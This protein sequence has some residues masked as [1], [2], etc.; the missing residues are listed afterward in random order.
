MTHDGLVTGPVG[1]TLDDA[2]EI[3]RRHKVEKL[4]IVDDAGFLKGLITVKDIQ[5]KIQFPA[6]RSEEHTSE[7]Q[8][9]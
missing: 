6:A 8:S 3:L 4:P 7:L 2:K 9:H 1:I 5:K